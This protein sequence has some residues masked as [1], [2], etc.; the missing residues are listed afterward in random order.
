MKTDKV[1]S[2]HPLPCIS[3]HDSGSMPIAEQCYQNRTK[4]NKTSQTDRFQGH[5]GPVRGFRLEKTGSIPNRPVSVQ[6]G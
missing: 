6:R 1:W 2:L 4:T 5:T 3:L